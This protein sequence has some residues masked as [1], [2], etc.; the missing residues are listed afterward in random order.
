[1][2]LDGYPEPSNPSGSPAEGLPK[3]SDFRLVE[4]PVT[5]RVGKSPPQYMEEE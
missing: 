5:R 3:P 2:K 4:T 1:M